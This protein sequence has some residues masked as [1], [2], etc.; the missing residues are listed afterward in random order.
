[1]V[2]VAYERVGRCLSGSRTSG[3]RAVRQVRSETQYGG[4]Q[5]RI[6][7]ARHC[8]QPGRG[9]HVQVVMDVARRLGEGQAG[10]RVL[11]GPDFHIVRLNVVRS[12]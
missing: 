12:F 8:G 1:M 4:A 7:A 9:N 10:N 3:C 11:M 2:E 6:P 5:T